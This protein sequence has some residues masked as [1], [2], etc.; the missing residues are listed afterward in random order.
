MGASPL[1]SDPNFVKVKCPQCGSEARRET[2]VSDT[3]LD[4]AWYFLRYPCVEM[5]MSPWGRELTKKWL[6]VDM[7]IGGAEHAVL[8]LLYSRFLTMVF[9]DLGLVDFEEPFTK[10][11]AHGLLISQ[12]AKMSKSK[13]NVVTPDAYIEKYGSDTLRC[14]LMFCGRFTQGGDFR[15]SGIEGMHRFLKRIWR[16]INENSKF[17]FSKKNFAIRNSK[18]SREAAHMMHKTI[19]RVTEDIESLD[20]NTAI[21][22]IMEWVNALEERTV[23]SDE[24]IVHSQDQ[25]NKKNLRT[26]NYELITR[27]EVQ[28]LLLLLA[29]FAPHMT[30]ELY[31]R[32][33]A[34]I[35][36]F[37]FQISNFKSIH[38]QAWPKYDP[39]LAEAQE[40][41]LVV[42]VNGKV[43][44]KIAV[45][46]GIGREE[47]QKLV[48]ES[49]KVTKYL[50]K[51]K[52][53]K[54]IFVPDR[55]IN[56]VI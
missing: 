40:I 50:H 25:K 3:F 27:E 41:V 32:L 30:E 18:L 19:K 9:K 24:F 4:S 47:A 6:P 48:L 51:G 36:N 53:K 20:Y 23:G 21:A 17:A 28:T 46:R 35:S 1:A 39:K 12:G 10:F 14:Y 33:H 38:T 54:V 55:L 42:E 43:R 31:Q 49:E 13:G 16:L 11:R 5:K 26:K 52:P 44:D 2:D 29:P 37:K 7:Y 15:D 8:H 34:G 22:A 45:T 56:F